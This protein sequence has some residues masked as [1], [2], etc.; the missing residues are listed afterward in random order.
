MEQSM[1]K[2]N[3]KTNR[4]LG[5]NVPKDTAAHPSVLQRDGST[6]KNERATLH[7]TVE[8]P[9]DSGVEFNRSQL[10]KGCITYGSTLEEK[11]Q[12]LVLLQRGRR[13]RH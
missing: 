12:E 5:K 6:N 2:L 7:Q 8:I 4:T 9:E 3:G 1:C 11:M 10:A 13:H